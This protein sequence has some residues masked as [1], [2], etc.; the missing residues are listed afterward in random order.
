MNAPLVRTQGLLE[1]AE[2]AYRLG[3]FDEALDIVA[4]AGVEA[5][6][7]RDQTN[8]AMVKRFEE[9][10]IK[11]RREG[12]DTPAAEKLFEKARE[13]FRAKKYRQA[14]ATALQSEPEAERISLQ[15]AIA[16]QAADS[17]AGNPPAPGSGP[18]MRGG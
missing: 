3:Q 13:V 11:A 6:K 12:T 16:K 4:Q 7:E 5:T 18:Q 17:V 9:G 15:Q 8:S 2:R 10:V 14:I 1:R